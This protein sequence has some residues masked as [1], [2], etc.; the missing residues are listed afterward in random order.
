MPLEHEKVLRH[1]TQY[2]IGL[3]HVGQGY[4]THANFKLRPRCHRTTQRFGQQL[5]AERLILATGG[6]SLPKTGSDGAGM[7]ATVGA[8][9]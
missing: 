8:A 1:A 4:G 3:S 5:R 9:L 2:G 6:L 7:V